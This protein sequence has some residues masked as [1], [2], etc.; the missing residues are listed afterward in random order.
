[1]TTSLRKDL[2]GKKLE[3]LQALASTRNIE[4]RSDMKRDEL[5]EKL[6]KDL[7]ARPPRIG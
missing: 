3:E 5:I 7:L 2:Q 4:G 1:M 6:E